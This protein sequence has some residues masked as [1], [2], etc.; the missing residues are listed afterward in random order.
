M[1]IQVKPRTKALGGLLILYVGLHALNGLILKQLA[2]LGVPTADTLLY[3]GLAC[4]AAAAL[5]GLWHKRSLWPNRPLLQVFRFFCSGLALWLITAAYG[6][7]NATTVSTISRLDTAILLVLGPIAGVASRPTQRVLAA[8]C[9]V[10]PM[11]VV[12]QGGMGSG[13]QGWGY[14]LAFLGTL[15]ITMG[16]LFLRSSAKTENVQVVALIAGLAI[17]AYGGVGHLAS[18]GPWLGATELGLCAVTGLVMYLLYDLTVRLYRVMD[19]AKAEYPTLIAAL[20]VMPA[21]ALLFHVR[22]P[23]GYVVAMVANVA[24]LGIILAWPGKKA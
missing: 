22:F 19:I 6:Y 10:L 2:N 15:G 23:L 14:L 21:E 16:Y 4:A 12:A 8:G 13:E 18:P 11:L 24:L 7:A 17:A 9:I 20:A 5:M 1:A 3:R